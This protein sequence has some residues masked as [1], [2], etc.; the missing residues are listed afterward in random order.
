MISRKE[1]NPHD[2][3]LTPEQQVNFDKL[4]EV[5]N[6][7]RSAYGRPMLVTSGVRSELDQARI[8]P[9]ARGSA[10]VRG[11]ACDISDPDNNVWGWCMDNL[12]LLAKLG[13]YLEDKRST[14]RWVHFQIFPPKS[15][16]RIFIP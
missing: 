5:M 14:P 15:G 8:N 4:C 1:L 3:D 6:A 13:L 12:A 11:G 9:K 16:N 2:Y 7:V 10:H